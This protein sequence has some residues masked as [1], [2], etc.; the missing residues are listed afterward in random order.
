MRLL[1]STWLCI[2]I[3]STACTNSQND[4]KVADEDGYS[5]YDIAQPPS[6]SGKRAETH[7][8]RIT[9]MKFVPDIV[10]VHKGDTIMWI[11]DDLVEHDVTEQ[12]LMSW[13]SSRLSPGT[14]WKMVATNSEGYYCSLHV[15]MKGQIVVDGSKLA[16]ATYP[17]PITQCD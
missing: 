8:V 13:T 12:T 17:P 11:N 14:A 5:E 1:L 15:I 3:A 16:M 2:A 7:I 9:Q 10:N 6:K 4:H